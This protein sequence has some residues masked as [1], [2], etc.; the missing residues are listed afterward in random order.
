M[1][2]MLLKAND[3][4]R[5]LGV[6]VREAYRLIQSRR[7]TSVKFGKTVRV[8]PEDLARFIEANKVEAIDYEAVAE[9]ICV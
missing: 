6:S 5:Y 8:T 3:V 4:A 2:T 9:T 7:I 1:A